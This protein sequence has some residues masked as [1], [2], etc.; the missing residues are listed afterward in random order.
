MPL[1]VIFLVWY[2][3]FGKNNPERYKKVEGKLW[4]IIT[5][6]FAISFISAFISPALAMGTVIFI[7]S[8]LP[9]FVGA[10]VFIKIVKSVGRFLTGDSKSTAQRNDRNIYGNA[11]AGEKDSD[12]FGSGFTKSVPK[13]K[14]ILGKFNKK[15][16]LN[17]SEEEMDRII[18]ASYV[19]V[20]WEREIR[21][22]DME[23]A[24]PAQWCRGNTAWLRVYLRVCPVKSISS[25]FARQRQ[26]CVNTFVH[27]FDDNNPGNYESI[28]ACISDMNFKFFTDLDEAMFMVIFRFLEGEGK[29]YTMPEERIISNKTEIDRLKEKYDKDLD[30]LGSIY[31]SVQPAEK[32]RL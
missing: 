5:G 8:L 19:S 10:A 29:H 30:T 16:N 2:F 15:Y 14:K 32:T 3:V 11:S 13:R 25:D 31:D 1:L 17:L 4:K 28:E 18:E 22:M 23:Y 20:A 12:I 9:V 26:I 27:M 6:L 21:D 7:F 24:V